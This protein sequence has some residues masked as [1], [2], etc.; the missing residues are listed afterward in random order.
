M[1]LSNNRRR[2]APSQGVVNARLKYAK[3]GEEGKRVNVTREE[4]TSAMTAIQE[5]VRGLEIQFRRIAQMQADIDEIKRTLAK[6]S[7]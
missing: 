3:E 1:G 5:N 7:R 4:F 2:G 6:Q